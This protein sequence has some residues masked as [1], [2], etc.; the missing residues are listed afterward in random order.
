[1]N[2]L[3]DMFDNDK[4]NKAVKKVKR[5]NLLTNIL[6]AV[7]VFFLSSALN[8]YITKIIAGISRNRLEMCTK[9]QIPNA[10]IGKSVDVLGFLGGSSHYTVYKEVGWRPVPLYSSVSSF[11]LNSMI[12][13]G[14]GIDNFRHKGWDVYHW[15][16]GYRQLIFFHPDIKYKKYK[17]DFEDFHSIPDD[18]IIEMGLSF[19]KKYN[20][21]NFNTLI[22]NVNISWLWLDTYTKEQMTRYK[23][24]VN[25]FYDKSSY[26]PEGS[27]LGIRT[28]GNIVLDNI[29]KDNYSGLLNRLRKL[30][31]KDVYNYLKERKTPPEVI[32][33]V[34]YGTKNELKTLI[35]N[36][37]IKGATIGVM[38]NKD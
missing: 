28:E 31:Y 32:G 12:S 38:R 1:M 26:I 22:P 6:I 7:I 15:E 19:D 13:S 9:I 25:E 5:K 17:K 27:V 29:F 18:K 34:V 21:R 20:I 4:L 14:T 30:G 3:E 11:G 35:N 16:N 23:K 2:K 8:S 33:V 37:H 36:P 10:Y 24:D